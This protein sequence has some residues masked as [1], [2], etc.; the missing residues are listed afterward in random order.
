MSVYAGMATVVV[1]VN[2]SAGGGD[3]ATDQHFLESEK[4]GT[5][6]VL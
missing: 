6:T 2:A 5:E 3:L 4:M 1:S